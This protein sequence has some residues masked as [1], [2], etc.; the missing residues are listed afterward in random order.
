MAKLVSKLDNA[1]MVL[2]SSFA[3]W[4][5]FVNEGQFSRIAQNISKIRPVV[6]KELGPTVRALE[7]LCTAVTTEQ[8]KSEA[9]KKRIHALKLQVLQLQQEVENLKDKIKFLEEPDDTL[10]AAGGEEGRRAG[11]EEGLRAGEEEGLRAGGEE[12]RE[13]VNMDADA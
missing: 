11:G 13:D 4:T 6:D 7:K 8:N 9:Q 3:A 12:R 2:D 5:T 10:V 1:F